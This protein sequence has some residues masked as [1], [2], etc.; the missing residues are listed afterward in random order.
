MIQLNSNNGSKNHPKKD[1]ESNKFFENERVLFWDSFIDWGILLTLNLL[2]EC[3]H[4]LP[5]KN[6]VEFILVYV[7]EFGALTHW[8][9]SLIPVCNRI[10]VH[11]EN[12]G[13]LLSQTSI[14]KKDKINIVSVRCGTFKSHWIFIRVNCKALRIWWAPHEMNEEIFWSKLL[15]FKWIGRELFSISKF[16]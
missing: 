10:V 16:S 15:L 3:F 6:W 11:R 8:C 5:K 9:T 2:L 4:T 14:E 1:R 7:W 12:F 13:I